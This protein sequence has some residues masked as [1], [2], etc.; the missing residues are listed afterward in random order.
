[1]CV[2]DSCRS[3]SADSFQ[4]A[5]TNNAL[6]GARDCGAMPSGRDDKAVGNGVVGDQCPRQ[7]S[8]YCL[9]HLIYGAVEDEESCHGQGCQG[10][11]GCQPAL[12]PT[13]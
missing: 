11:G 9:C 3:S 10:C 1:V 4:V 6:I 5:A 13:A 7:C 12:L 2:N 8:P